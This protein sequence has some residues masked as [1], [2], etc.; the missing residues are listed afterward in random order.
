ML[1]LFRKQK[2]A[3][4]WILGFIT[5]IMAL[6]MVVFFIP[7]PTAISDASSS[8]TIA[9]VGKTEVSAGDYVATFRRFLKSSN[10]PKDIEFLKQVGVPRQLLDQLIIQKLLIEEAKS[11]GLEASDRELKEKLLTSPLFQQMGGGVNMQVYTRVLQQS[12]MSVEEFEADVRNQILIDKLR[13]LITDA[14]VVT[15]EEAERYYRNSSEK[16]TIDYVLFDPAEIEKTAA[17]DEA[18]LKKYYEDNKKRFMTTEQ[19]RAKFILVN[20]NKIRTETRARDED[21]RQYYDQNRIRYFANDRTRISQILFITQGKSP[22][23]V[24]KIR[25]KALEVLAKARAGADFA[26]L[27]KEYSDDAATKGA[28]G[29]QGWVDSNTNFFPEVKQVALSLGVGAV[30]DLVNTRFGLQILKATDHQAAHTMSFE[31]AK[32]QIRPTFLAQKSDREGSA[33]AE[34]IYAA[35]LTKPNDFEGIARQFG[36]EIRETPLFAVGDAVPE[37]GSN[38]DFEK[39]VFGTAL[40]AIG[41]P[42]RVSPGFVIPNVVEIKPPHTPELSEIR[43]RVERG[44][45][46]VRGLELAKQKAEAFAKTAAAAKDFSSPAKAGGLKVETSDPF[47]R[48][49]TDKKLGDVR[50]ISSAAFAMKTGDTS[51]ALKL[52]SRFIVFRLKAKEEMKP[53][54]FEKAKAATTEELLDQKRASAF[55]SFQ[56]E[57]LA[58]GLRDGS[59]KINEKALNAALNKRLG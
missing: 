13:H 58:R 55:Q 51:T 27:A 47:R 54:E 20:M 28:G 31:E 21:L 33:L 15:P 23:E 36:A 25:Q 4:K 38:P 30:S 1:D 48:N 43:A 8:A 44:F 46:N 26:Q 42:V 59:I 49:A 41:Q 12:G 50:D 37:I 32:E 45:K 19:R 39:R 7:A 14:I 16:V 35:V 18:A 17:V 29:D 5:G 34:K 2:A 3:S 9:Q 57:L 52:G 53:E 56:D 6:G 40:N 22:E 10:Y 11:F 24:E